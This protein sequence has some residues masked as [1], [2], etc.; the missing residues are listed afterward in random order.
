MNGKKAKL[1][2]RVAEDLQDYKTLKRG[3]RALKPR[4]LRASINEETMK[5]HSKDNYKKFIKPDKYRRKSLVWEDKN[6]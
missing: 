5:A 3:Y 4:K 2:R 1:I 6:T